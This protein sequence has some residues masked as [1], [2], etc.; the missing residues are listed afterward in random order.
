[1]LK[2]IFRKILI[3]ISFL[4]LLTAYYSANTACTYLVYQEELPSEVKKLRKF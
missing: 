2:Y 3:C 4:A 1:M